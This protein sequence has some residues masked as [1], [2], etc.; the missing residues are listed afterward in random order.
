MPATWHVV[1]SHQWANIP[2][3]YRDFHQPST[4][5]CSLWNENKAHFSFW[6]ITSTEVRIETLFPKGKNHLKMNSSLKEKL[7]LS[8]LSNWSRCVSLKCKSD[9]WTNILYMRLQYVWQWG[10]QLFIPPVTSF[11]NSKSVLTVWFTAGVNQITKRVWGGNA[12][13]NYS[14]TGLQWKLGFHCY[15]NYRRRKNR[16]KQQT[17]MK[18]LHFSEHNMQMQSYC[19]IL[20][21]SN[22]AFCFSI[23]STEDS[24]L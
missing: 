11:F 21:F 19:I 14:G 16:T 3:R 7:F 13:K 5:Q 20:W 9:F 24:V 4:P 6:T 23:M 8:H 1:L 22:L 18:I 10:A 17:Y 2:Y 12:M 15:L